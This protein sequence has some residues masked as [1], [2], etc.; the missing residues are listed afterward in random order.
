MKIYNGRQEIIRKA[1]A[2]AYEVQ[3][4][5]GDGSK[6]LN[7]TNIVRSYSREKKG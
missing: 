2:D 7:L 3:D 4:I 1:G 6:I 5:N